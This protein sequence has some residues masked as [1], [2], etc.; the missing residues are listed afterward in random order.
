MNP[1]IKLISSM[2]TRQ[3]LADLVARYQAETGA[4]VEVESVGAVHAAK[5]VEDGEAFDGVVLASN[6]IDKLVAAG[7]VAGERIDLVNSGIFVAVQAGAAWPDISSEAAVKQAVLAAPT[8]GYSTGASGVAL[9]QLFER[10]G[11]AAEIKPRVVTPP[12]GTPVGSLVAAGQVALGFQQLS[13]MKFL[14][15]IDV[16]GPLPPSIQVH[17]VFSG[18]VVATSRQ[19][20]AVRAFFAFLVSPEVADVKIANGMEPHES[21]PGRPKL[22]HPPRAAA[23]TPPG[24]AL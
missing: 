21:T 11:I 19:A 9:A 8:L 10:W 6:A 12:P 20:E 18:G 17:T 3:L 2:A 5:R 4:V 1:P 14:P 7:R 16:V 13:E 23:A 22:T 24:G 15:G